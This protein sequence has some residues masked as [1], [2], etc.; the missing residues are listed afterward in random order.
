MSRRIRRLAVATG[1]VIV[2]TAAGLVG[3]TQV[4]ANPSQVPPEGT[5]CTSQVRADAGAVL[6]GSS[7]VN[8]GAGPLWSI[9]VAG[10]AGGAESE[11]L[12][13]PARTLPP[14]SVVP[15]APGTWYFRG[16]LKNTGPLTTTVQLQ[17]IPA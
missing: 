17:I 9:R 16:C 8:N 15:P 4:G 5:V 1:A 10:S 14:T 13:T 2:A 3:A 11:V 6:S 12:R 7:T